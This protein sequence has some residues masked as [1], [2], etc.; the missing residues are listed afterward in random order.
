VPSG[1]LELGIG[2]VDGF[3]FEGFLGWAGDEAGDGA[4]FEEFGDGGGVGGEP[5]EFVPCLAGAGAIDAGDVFEGGDEAWEFL[6]IGNP[7][8]REILNRLLGEDG[9]AV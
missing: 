1:D 8:F 9:A 3:G 7:E 5:E 4:D 6:A 2:E